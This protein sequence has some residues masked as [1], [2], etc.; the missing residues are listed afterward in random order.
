M[1][2][3]LDESSALGATVA[4]VKQEPMIA[5]EQQPQMETQSGTLNVE[6]QSQPQSSTNLNTISVPVTGEH[7]QSELI[8]LL[9]SNQNRNLTTTSSSTSTSFPS[10]SAFQ[11]CQPLESQAIY[12]DVAF[13]TSDTKRLIKLVN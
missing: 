7:R 5:E 2:F 12:V 10:S 4:T 1:S 6:T 13:D 3:I 11:Q 9:E 8:T